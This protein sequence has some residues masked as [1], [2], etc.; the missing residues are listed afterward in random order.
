VPGQPLIGVDAV[1]V[2]ARVTGTARVLL[3]VLAQLPAVDPGLEYLAF[4]TP[5]G[6]ETLR[7]HAPG[8]GVQVVPPG[9]GLRWEL[10]GA[11]EAGAT[12]R[13]DLL[14]TLRELVP[15][16]G[17]PVLV[18]IA[19]PP[20]YRL[21]AFGSPS[22]PEARRFAKDVVLALGFGRSLRR[23][24]AVTAASQTT[25]DWLRSHAGI[26]P[27]VVLPGVDESFRAGEPMVPAAPPYVFHLASGDP[28]DNTDLVLRAFATR[29]CAGLR[30]VLAGA[31]E[32]FRE[33]L[34]HRTAELGIDAEILGWVSDERLRELYRGAL[35]F[36]H[37]TKY[38]GYAGLPVLEA[39]ALGTPVV[40]LDAP[41]ATEA[42]EGVGI[43][44]PREDPDLLADEFARL[45]DDP[46]LRAELVSRGRALA[47]GLTWEKTAAG[48]AAAFR[49]ALSP[50]PRGR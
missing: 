25:A 41:G 31:P 20:V 5:S 46:S 4:V 27:D 28:R 8:V 32:H 23:A 9:R 21:R 3:N 50:S 49:K 37:P 33:R 39:M 34:E 13:I 30:L 40:V 19:E 44:V 48:F 45:R 10:R 16:G 12:A 36:A 18:H 42:V 26:D 24:R 14:F 17:A 43:V 6:E 38:E 11:A 7:E 47:H 29:T 15:L 1:A 35:A 22:V 2:G